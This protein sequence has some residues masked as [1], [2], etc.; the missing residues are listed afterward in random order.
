M[1]LKFFQIRYWIFAG[2]LVPLLMSVI[3]GVIISSDVEASI[4]YAK[5]LANTDLVTTNLGK[6]GISIERMLSSLRGYLIL[7]NTSY[8]REYNEAKR[9]YE[10]LTENLDEIIDDQWQKEN[11]QELSKLVNDL[12]VYHQE[13]INLME[14]DQRDAAVQ[15]WRTGIGQD[16]SQEITD[17]LDT[18][19]ERGEEMLDISSKEQEEDLRQLGNIVWTTTIVS[20]VS[21]LGIGIFII[22]IIVNKINQEATAVAAS[23]SQIAAT[24]EEQERLAIQQ[25]ASVNQTTTSI[26]EVGASARQSAEQIRSAAG[27]AT[28]ILGLASGNDQTKHNSLKDKIER[29]RSQILRLSEHLSQISSVT[30]IVSDLANQTN[31]LALN[32]SVE[33]VRAGEHGKGFGVVAVEIRKLADESRKSAEKINSLII[34]I[35]NATNSTV[36]VTEEGTQAVE[37]II[38][39]INDVA[40]NIQQISLNAQQQAG[41][42]QQVVEAM[43]DLNKTAQENT[44]GIAQ[45]KTGTQQLQQTAL[46][47]RDMI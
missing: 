47:L 44:T 21:V 43:N 17:K 41:A 36:V 19:S 20:L 7:E 23:A 2:Y 46:S 38:N 29:V 15:Q 35:Q 14:T 5:E 37:N 1:M 27:G 34:D 42:V 25:A 18:F 31:M 30:T 3:S 26:D 45:T 28:Q 22:S 13:L 12:T 24:I 16:L 10:N 39:A 6:L 33:A 8:L 4:Q 32:A 11:F 40:V 9:N